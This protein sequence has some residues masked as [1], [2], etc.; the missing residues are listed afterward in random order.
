MG[1]TSASEKDSPLTQ[2]VDAHGKGSDGYFLD[3][4]CWGTYLHGILDNATVIDALLAPFTDT[5]G[6]TIDHRQFK[7]A[8]YDKLAALLRRHLDMNS[9]YKTLES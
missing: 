2:F 7:E 4:R 9:I 8:Q 1:V 3:D 6:Q 5:P